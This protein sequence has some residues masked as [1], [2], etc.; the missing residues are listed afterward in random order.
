MKGKELWSHIAGTNP[1]PDKEKEKEKYV[2]WEVKNA[3]EVWN[4]L[5]FSISSLIKPLEKSGVI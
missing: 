1:A 3:Q 4:P 2:K 5:Y